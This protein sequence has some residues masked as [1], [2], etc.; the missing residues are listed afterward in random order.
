MAH[1]VIQRSQLYRVEAREKFT[2]VSL[3]HPAV[4]SC[5]RNVEMAVE[6]ERN[7]EQSADGEDDQVLDEECMHIC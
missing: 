2:D 6:S 3:V 4:A 5:F 1:Q 7:Q